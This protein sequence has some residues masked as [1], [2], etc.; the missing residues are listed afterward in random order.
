MLRISQMFTAFYS[1]LEL[2]I[3][4]FYLEKKNT[5]VDAFDVLITSSYLWEAK[6]LTTLKN[7]LMNQA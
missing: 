7:A 5:S 4:L 2:A 3:M 1:Y 6:F